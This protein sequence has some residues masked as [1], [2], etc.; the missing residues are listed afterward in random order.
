MK[1]FKTLSDRDLFGDY[2]EA[3]DWFLSESKFEVYFRPG[4][5]ESEIESL[6]LWDNKNRIAA[7]T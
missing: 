6:P 3:L 2:A 1:F 7:F 4:I 5:D